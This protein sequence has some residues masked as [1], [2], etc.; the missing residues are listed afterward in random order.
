MGFDPAGRV[1]IRGVWALRGLMASRAQ[2]VLRGLGFRAWGCG[3]T[4]K[5]IADHPIS[6]SIQGR[7]VHGYSFDQVSACPKG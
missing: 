7:S 3:I 2:G 6:A 1:Q 4:N 5:C